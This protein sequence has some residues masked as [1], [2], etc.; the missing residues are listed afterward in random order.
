M[1]LWNLTKIKDHGTV[2]YQHLTEDDLDEGETLDA[3]VN[4]PDTVRQTTPEERA[5]GW[6]E[7]ITLTNHSPVPWRYI[8]GEDDS[9]DRSRISR[10]SPD[11]FELIFACEVA[12]V[13]EITK[14]NWKEVWT[15]LNVQERLM[16]NLGLES[17]PSLRGARMPDVVEAHIGLLLPNVASLTPKQ[18][19]KKMMEW[20]RNDAEARLRVWTR[21][22]QGGE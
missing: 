16:E 8:K 11:T 10:M 9:D 2:C 13:R 21:D 5:K 18:F 1:L 20:L 12:G 14:K 22:F 7:T 4:L 17:R 6:G 3:L 15:R 19:D